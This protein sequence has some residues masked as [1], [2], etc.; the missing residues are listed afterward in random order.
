MRVVGRDLGRK[1]NAE[2]YMSSH[3]QTV[4][5]NNDFLHTCFGA[6]GQLWERM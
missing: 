3:K 6:N 4:L 1:Q 2:Q 5:N